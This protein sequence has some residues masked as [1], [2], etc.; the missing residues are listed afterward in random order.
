MS[1]SRITA[2]ILRSDNKINT[3]EMTISWYCGPMLCY[4]FVRTQMNLTAEH[5]SCVR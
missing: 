1:A 3:L 2:S 5:V 4:D